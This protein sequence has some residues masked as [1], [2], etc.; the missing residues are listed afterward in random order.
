MSSMG[1]IR[2]RPLGG[3]DGWIGENETCE[4]RKAISF[5]SLPH[6]VDRETKQKVSL[7]IAYKRFY[8]DGQA[9]RKFEIGVSIYNK[10]KSSISKNITKII[11]DDLFNSEVIIPNPAGKP[12]K[13]ILRDAGKYLSKLYYYSCTK[14][15]NWSS[16]N[17]KHIISQPPFVFFIKEENIEFT[18]PYRKLQEI[19]SNI[20]GIKELTCYN[21]SSNNENIYIFSITSKKL[22]NKYCCGRQLRI[23]LIRLCLENICLRTVFQMIM[24]HTLQISGRGYYSNALQHYLNS[25]IKKIYKDTDTIC[26]S[27]NCEIIDVVNKFFNRI[28]PGQKESLTSELKKMDLRPNIIKKFNEHVSSNF[29]IN[30]NY[31]GDYIMGDKNIF[32]NEVNAGAIG[33]NSHAENFNFNNLW[34]QHSS[35]IDLNDL[36][37]ELKELRLYIS[38]NITDEDIVIR[39]SDIINA[40]NEAIKGNGSKTLKYLASTGGMLIDVAK[41][42]GTNVVTKAI[43]VALGL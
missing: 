34:N 3:I 43:T 40:E 5:V 27:D 15:K 41:K 32:N 42:A 36:A 25:T 30:N 7:N 31:E 23:I 28:Y 35:L 26:V 9:L 13:C 12:Y 8:S 4:A 33:S 19:N 2:R 38:T 16:Y 17:S 1:V 24:G 22:R 37:K 20:T 14:S 6:Y 39:T 18:I 10:Y 21:Y 29:Y 11:L